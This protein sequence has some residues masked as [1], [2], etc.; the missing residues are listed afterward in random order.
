[1]NIVNSIQFF[2][3]LNAKAFHMTIQTIYPGEYNSCYSHYYLLRLL[4]MHGIISVHLKTTYTCWQYIVLNIV[5]KHLYMH[6][7]GHITIC[8]MVFISNII[9]HKVHVLSVPVTLF[10]VHFLINLLFWMMLNFRE[11]TR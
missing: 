11:W 3:T 8:L 5:I 2:L 10:H 6:V 4:M 1:M 7:F 9:I